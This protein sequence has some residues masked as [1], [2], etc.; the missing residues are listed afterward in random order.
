MEC[1]QCLFEMDSLE[2]SQYAGK[3]NLKKDNGDFLFLNRR[4]D[5]DDLKSLQ[6]LYWCG[7]CHTV[8]VTDAD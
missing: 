8:E 7:M 2:Y 1:S 3:F 5:D 4:E 6:P